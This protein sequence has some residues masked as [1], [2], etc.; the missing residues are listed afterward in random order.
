[1]AI[2]INISFSVDAP[3]E[4]DYVM[5]AFFFTDIAINFTTAYYEHGM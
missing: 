3:D 5:D 2:P 4:L 1:M